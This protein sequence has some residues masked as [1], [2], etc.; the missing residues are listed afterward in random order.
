M[1]RTWRLIRDPR[2]AFDAF[3]GVGA[4][5]YGGRWNSYGTHVVYT[6]QSVALAILE[7]L[8]HIDPTK[9]ERKALL[10]TV[11]FSEALVE[12][13]GA[14]DLPNDWQSEPPGK[15]PKYFGDKWK[16]EARSA[17][18]KVPSVLAPTEWNFIISPAHPDFEKIRIAEYGEIPLDPRLLR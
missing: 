12:V 8:V 13:I 14:K 6:S 4:A 10:F 2:F 17:V 9:S 18:L 1:I 11:D 3:T 7:I 15:A 5:R 16:K